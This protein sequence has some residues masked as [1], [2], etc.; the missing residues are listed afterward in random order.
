MIAIE[1][2]ETSRQLK[3][4]ITLDLALYRD[5]PLYAPPVR[6]DVGKRLRKWTRHRTDGKIP[7]HEAALY[8]AHKDGRVVGRISASVDQTK[9]DHDGES[10]GAFGFL[11]GVSDPGVFAALFVAAES[12][13]RERGA[14]R[15]L[16]PYSF[17]QEDPYVGLLVEGFDE[18]PTFGMTYSLPWYPAMVEAAGYRGVMDL[19]S[20]F[21]PSNA[22]PPKILERVQPLLS[23]ADVNV[24]EIDMRHVWD[25][26]KLL[27]N[28]FNAALRG[29]WEFVPFPDEQVQAMVEELRL[30][31][32]PRVIL[33]AEV[34]GKTAGAVI[35]IPDYNDVLRQTRGTLFPTG[36]VRLLLAKGNRTRLRPYA[37][38]VL[39][40]YRGMGI[41]ALLVYETFKRGTVAGYQQAE[42]T[43]VLGNN[44]PMNDLALAFAEPRGKMHRIYEK[45]LDA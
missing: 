35:N 4:F 7:R 45:R 40:P 33:I 16:G 11:E 39:E 31:A 9:N 13:L 10:S 18:P 27:R 37:L 29:N 5:H 38:G 8:L 25:E 42:V 2:V 1:R 36:L 43:W 26:A 23:R 34:D 12:W 17:I 32:D 24:R 30:I 41:G 3:T 14:R 44:A 28:V 22:L 19:R 15:V 21:V 20:Y 6:Y